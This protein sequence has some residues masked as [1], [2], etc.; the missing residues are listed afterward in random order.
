MDNGQK[1]KWECK[2]TPL[3]H[4]GVRVFIFKQNWNL[5]LVGGAY[6]L[7]ETIIQSFKVWEFLLMKGEATG[8]FVGGCSFVVVVC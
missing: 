7:A 6:V 3:C 4:A 8:L 5:F 1:W 2:M